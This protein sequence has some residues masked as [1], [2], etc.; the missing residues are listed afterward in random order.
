MYG[1]TEALGELQFQYIGLC[2]SPFMV[3]RVIAKGCTLTILTP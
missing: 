3:K 2:A 1:L